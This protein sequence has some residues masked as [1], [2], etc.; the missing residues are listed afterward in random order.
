MTLE[1]K[2]FI[3]YQEGKSKDV[4]TI[5]LNPEERELLERSKQILEQT[6]DSTCLKQLAFIGAKLLGEEKTTY[7]LGV[8][9]SNKRK[10]KRLGI[11]DFE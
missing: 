4:V 6:K 3:R 11:P 5:W 1:K 8:V 2:P 7:L 9:Y 10:N